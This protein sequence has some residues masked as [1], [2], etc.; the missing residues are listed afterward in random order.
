MQAR[1]SFK[2]TQEADLQNYTKD[3][4]SVEIAKS[5]QACDR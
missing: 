2:F 3:I 1:L 4:D 5:F